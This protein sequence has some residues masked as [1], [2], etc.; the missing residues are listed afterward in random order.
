MLRVLSALIDMTVGTIIK[1]TA[2]L[3]MSVII[4]FAIPGA[5]FYGSTR[6]IDKTAGLK[7]NTTFCRVIKSGFRGCKFILSEIMR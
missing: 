4:S 1:L 6:A 5:I 3:I 7:S 2:S